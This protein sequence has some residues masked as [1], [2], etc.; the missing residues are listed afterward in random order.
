MDIP[1]KS[2]GVP[3]KSV[4]R[5]RSSLHGTS[6][7]IP[8]TDVP[9]EFLMRRMMFR[10]IGQAVLLCDIQRYFFPDHPKSVAEE[11]C[12]TPGLMLFPP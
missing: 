3:R 2:F 10:P 9:M 1:R 12:D 7:D 8:G 6:A 4:E 5:P 11:T